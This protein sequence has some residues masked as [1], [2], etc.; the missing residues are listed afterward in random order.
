MNT[1]K[2]IIYAATNIFIYEQAVPIY[3]H[4][5]SREKDSAVFWTQCW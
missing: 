1:I 5:I 4:T 3:T 2:S